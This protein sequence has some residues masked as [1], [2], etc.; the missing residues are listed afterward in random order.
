MRRLGVLRRL[1]ALAGAVAMV[2]AAIQFQARADEGA[3]VPGTP[4]ATCG[5]GSRPEPGMQ[6]R[7]SADDVASGRAAE[8]FTCNAEQI[9]HYGNT[10]GFRVHRYVD[11][12]GR[13]CAYYDPTLLFPTALPR[14]GTDLTGIYVLDMTDPAR[15]VKTANLLSLAAQS[16]HESFSLNVPRGLLAV[17]LGNPFA[18]PGFVDVYDISTDCRSPVLKSSLPVGF[19]GHEGAFSPDGNTYWVS[20]AGG[21][22]LTAVDLTDPARPTPVWSSLDYRIH[23]LNISDDGNRL[24][25]AALGSGGPNDGLTTLDVTQVQQRVPD[26]QVPLVSHLSW[27]N[28]S[29][30]QVPI[31]VTIGGRPYIVEMDEFAG[32]PIPSTDPTANVGAARIIDMADER[33]PR[34]IS[35]IRLEVNQR[36]N[37]AQLTSDPGTSSPVGGYAGH[38]CAVPQR[39]EPGI[40]ACSFILSGLRVFDIRDPYNPKE[41]AYFNA[42]PTQGT[43]NF[44]PS[45]FAMSAPAFVPERS[46]V[47]YSDGNSGFYAVRLTN[48]VW[49]F[50]PEPASAAPEVLG[51]VDRRDPAAPAL[52][53]DSARLPSTGGPGSWPLVGLG[54]GLAGVVARRIRRL[55]QTGAGVWKPQGDRPPPRGRPAHAVV[56]ALGRWLGGSG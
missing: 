18:G 21:G 42:P 33:A 3:P 4:R 36:E 28:I 10:G 40:V 17:D 20:S 45:S 23:G 38:Y 19:L 22:T 24:Y 9:G 52:A 47:W 2:A 8:G 34:V 31:P 43:S 27:P 16:P 26:P 25:G 53:S 14:S 51:Q 49:P 12:A 39:T 1:A 15:P 32:G 37:R 13:E 46:E 5:P 41:L 50:R 54:L 30:P 48:G 56:L 44:E 6:G 35:E 55:E 11:A 7:V 29:I